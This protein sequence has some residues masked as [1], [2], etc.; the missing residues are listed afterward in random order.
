MTGQLLLGKYELVQK[1]AR[2][3]MAE[4]FLAKVAGPM[5]FEKTLVVKRILPHLAEEANFVGMFLAEA[6]L[7]AQLNHPNVVQVFDFGEADGTY[8]LVMEFVDGLNLRHLF[9]EAMQRGQPVDVR[10]AAKIIAMAC[11]GLAYAHDFADPNT[12]EPMGLVHRDISPDNVLVGKNGAV[13]V[14]DFGIAK[15]AGQTNLTKTGTIKGKI[16]YMPPEQVANET[17]DRR[18]DVYALG[19][20]LYEVLTGRKPFDTTNDAAIVKAILYEQFP[21]ASSFRSDVPEQLQ[22][23]LDRALAKSVAE[24]YPDCRA[25]QADLERFLRSAGEPVSQYDVAQLV[26]RLMEHGTAITRPIKS[27][28]GHVV[29]PIAVVAPSALVAPQV[30]TA[31]LSIAPVKAP[32]PAPVQSPLSPPAPASKP[33]LEV[34]ELGPPDAPQLLATPSAA[35]PAFVLSDRPIQPQSMGPV[36]TPRPR[37]A[38]KRGSLV[39]GAVAA[40]LAAVG[41]LVGAV[42][43]SRGGSTTPADLKPTDAGVAAVAAAPEPVQPPPALPAPPAPA[44][45]V[46]PTPAPDVPSPTTAPDVTSP[47]VPVD[48]QAALD[49]EVD[50]GRPGPVAAPTRAPLPTRRPP[51]PKA[52]AAEV[53]VEF[54][55]RP[56]G[57]VY[58]DGTLVGET[59]FAALPLSVGRHTVRVVNKDLGQ[60]VTRALDVKAGAATVFRHSFD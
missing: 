34:V 40:A 39:A 16:A 46:T 36:L 24:R 3:G 41:V 6:R 42:V 48:A 21:P 44:P 26:G 14:V 19:I 58:V 12:Q 60:E 2:G 11:D 37:R 15:A 23:V 10:V 35:R 56:F 50:A 33:A 38:A 57:T 49:V 51:K 18:T 4:V 55:I 20:V 8:V 17:L 31:Q 28:P 43:L 27:T 53:P 9:R 1:L 5:G 22:R 59:P 54:R 29:P 13:K 32:E 7:A 47:T 25:F 45:T 30:P 52:A